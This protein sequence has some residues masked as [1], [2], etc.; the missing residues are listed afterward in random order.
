MTDVSAQSSDNAAVAQA[1]DA[2]YKAVTSKSQQQLETLL[3]EQLSFGHSVG[4]IET[5]AQCIAN[6]MSPR[7]IW[8]SVAPVDQS[9]HIAGDAAVVRHIM[10][11]EN[12]REGKSSAVSMN[13]LMVWQ[14]Q[15]GAWKMLARQAFKI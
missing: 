2:F 4:R 11:G 5:K 1:I 15:N 6:A 10:A 13:V 9:I 7:V 3:A 14:K 12:E 8:K